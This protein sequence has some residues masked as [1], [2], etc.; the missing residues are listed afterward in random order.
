M[1]PSCKGIFLGIFLTQFFFVLL[2]SVQN[3]VLW[4]LLCFT[5]DFPEC[6]HWISRN[7]VTI[8]AV[9]ASELEPATCCVRDQDP[10]TVPA[11]HA[12]ETG[13]LNWDQFMLEWVLRSLNSQK[14]LNSVNVLLHLEK[15]QCLSPLSCCTSF[16]LFA[17]SPTV[18]LCLSLL[19]KVNY[20]SVTYQIGHKRFKVKILAELSLIDRLATR[21][22]CEYL[23]N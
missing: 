11:R 20:L 14:S 23:I 2:P 3:L 18:T 22:K 4:R 21:C 15:I 16:S 19:S 5:G 8:N 17:N 7:S 12:W 9:S 1:F 10:T 13:Y 6:F